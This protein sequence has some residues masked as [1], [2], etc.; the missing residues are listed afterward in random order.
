MYTVLKKIIRDLFDIA[1]VLFFI[2]VI[3]LNPYTRPKETVR[4]GYYSIEKR[5]HRLLM[6]LTGHTFLELRDEN[7][8]IVYQIHGLA[9]NSSTGAW[10]EIGNAG[11]EY[12]RAWEFDGDKY[13][14]YRDLDIGRT[15]VEIVTGDKTHILEKWAKIRDCSLQINQ[16]NIRY[17]RYGFNIFSETENS[18]SV[19]HTLILC[20]GLTDKSVGLFSPGSKT[21][22][23]KQ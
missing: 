2:F 13:K 3:L 23:L 15:G 16:K 14:T 19:A 10:E 18:N 8:N 17:S 21:D 5:E 22:L 12:L 11:T 6:G 9:T 7:G 1:I 20:A 4:R